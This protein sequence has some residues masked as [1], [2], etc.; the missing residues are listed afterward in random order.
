MSPRDVIVSI[1]PRSEGQ[2]LHVT[3][4][5]K[6]TA[7]RAEASAA[8]YQTARDQAMA[9]LETKVNTHPAAAC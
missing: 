1:A 5:H 8:D 7:E 6:P 9:E 2:P 3:L 4:T